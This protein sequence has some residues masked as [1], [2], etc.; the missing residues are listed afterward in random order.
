M[1]KFGRIVFFSLFWAAVAV[2]LIMIRKPRATGRSES[3][4]SLQ[5]NHRSMTIRATGVATAAALSGS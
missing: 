1:R 4:P 2:I 5:S 3:R